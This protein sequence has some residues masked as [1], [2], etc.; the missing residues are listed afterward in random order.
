MASDSNMKSANQTY[1]G[2]TAMMKWG[3]VATII[4]SALVVLLISG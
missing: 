3:T 1:A 4:V 2:F